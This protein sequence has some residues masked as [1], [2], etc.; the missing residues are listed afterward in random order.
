[1]PQVLA[2]PTR[3]VDTVFV[4]SGDKFEISGNP[5][6]PTQC[7]GLHKLHSKFMQMNPACNFGMGWGGVVW[8]CP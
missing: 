1:M 8:V 2:S 7:D 6:C 5:T 4:M 3:N